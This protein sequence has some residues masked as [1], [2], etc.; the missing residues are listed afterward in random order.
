MATRTTPTKMTA[1]EFFE[2]LN[3]QDNGSRRFELEQGEPVEIP[4]PGEMHGFVCWLAIKLLTEYVG[5]RNK[6]YMFIN[7]AGLVVH[8]NPDTVRRPDVMYFSGDP[9]RPR[10]KLDE[11]IP[12][13]IVEV[14]SPSDT[15]RKT[16]ISVGQYLKHGVKL[17]W[18]LDPDERIIYVHQPPE[19]GKV[20]D[21]TDTLTGNGVLPDFSCPVRDL[22]TLPG[23]KPAA[24]RPTRTRPRKGNRE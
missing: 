2:W 9:I 6:G 1:E 20:L 8:R 4:L 14:L 19:F 18:A 7:D 22:F 21:E 11:R 12:D 5:E 17:V 15:M 24:P 13:L 16:T 10:R 3:R 23:Q